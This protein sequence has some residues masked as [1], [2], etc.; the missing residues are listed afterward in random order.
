M[1]TVSARSLKVTVI[2]DPATLLTVPVP[3][4]QPRVAL[5]I[6]LPDRTV[7]ADLNA[8][9][10]RKALATIREHGAEGVACIV[11]G[12]LLAGDQIAE[13]GLVVQPKVAK[14]AAA[15]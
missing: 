7:S 2:L 4:G 5:T 15:A 11:Q 14:V 13:A 3:D 1:P 6:R 12:K 9:G 10:V 8:K